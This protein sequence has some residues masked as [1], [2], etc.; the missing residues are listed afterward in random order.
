MFAELS[1][2]YRWLRSI[3]RVTFVL[4]CASVAL[5]AQSSATLPAAALSADA[6]RSTVMEVADTVAREYMDGTVA[7]R[8]A[9]ALRRRL[10]EGQYSDVTTP[11]A[12]ATRLT[13]DLAAESQDKHLAVTLAR[14][15]SSTASAST[16]VSMREEAARR[17]NGGVQRV[18]ILPGNVG[19]LNLV[20]FWRPDEAREP[21]GAAMRL[22]ERAD[23]LIV[24]MRENSGGSP[25]TVALLMGHFFDAGGLPMFDIVSRSGEL[26]T[27]ATPTSAPRE[28]RPKRPAYVLTASRTFSAGEGLAFLLQERRRAEVIGE[29]TVGAANPGRPYRVGSMFDVTVPNGK[30]RSA[31]SGGN[32]EGRGVN[33]DVAVAAA[34]ALRVAHSRALKRLIEDAEGDWAVRLKQILQ[35]LEAPP[36]GG[37]LRSGETLTTMNQSSALISRSN[38]S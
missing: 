30:V 17:A 7:A 6:V 19:Y 1:P 21:I 12:L 13:R 14:G 25:G 29:R 35:S 18:D 5:S 36:P 26:V 8:L 15:S 33:P 34:D 3:A 16:Q 24:D 2:A 23:A 20:S 38:C 28:R 27:Y 9:D 10:G 37:D 31:V 11:D 4:A 22:L 32:W